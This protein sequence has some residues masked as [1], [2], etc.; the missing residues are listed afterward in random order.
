MPGSKK[1]VSVCLGGSAALHTVGWR[2]WQ[3]LEGVQIAPRV[4]TAK[5]MRR[6]LNCLACGEA[7][8][9]CHAGSSPAPTTR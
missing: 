6:M 7:H 8:K 9:E 1:K 2:N 3:T 4:A 5:E